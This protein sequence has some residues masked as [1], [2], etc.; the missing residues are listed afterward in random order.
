MAVA[1]VEQAIRLIQKRLRDYPATPESYKHMYNEIT[2]RDILINPV[3]ESLGWDIHDFDH[4]GIEWR[5]STRESNRKADYV[6]FDRD[7]DP[8]VVIEAKRVREMIIN[9]PAKMETQLA[10]YSKGMK[11]GVA[12]LTNGL[13]WHIYDLQSSRRAMKNKHIGHV[14]DIR[15]GNADTA[16]CARILHRWLNKRKLWRPIYES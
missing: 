15:E 5:M 14:V 1:S 2:T 9:R 3:I 12:V 7:G 16:K 11:R 6:L 8:V 4:A 13:I 10:G